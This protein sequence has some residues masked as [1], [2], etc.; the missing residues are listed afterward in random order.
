MFLIT[1]RCS[2]TIPGQSLTVIDLV[3]RKGIKRAKTAAECIAE[4]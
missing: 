3:H 1:M 2:L 4:P